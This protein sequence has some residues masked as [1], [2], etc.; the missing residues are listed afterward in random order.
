[1]SKEVTKKEESAIVTTEMPSYL[2]EQMDNTT[3]N[4]EVESGDLVIPRVGIIQALS[5]QRKKNDAA[6]IDGAEEGMIF[7]NVSSELYGE[8]VQVVPVYFKKEYLLWVDRKAG[9]GFRGAFATEAEAISARNE[10]EKANDIEVA[11]T[12]QNFVIIIRS[13]GTIDEAVISMSRSQMKVS[14][15]W[16]SIIR[17]A[18]GPRFSRVYSLSSIEEQNANGDSYL[19]WD[20]KQV[21]FPPEDVFKRAEKL[22]DAVS[23]GVATAD[24]NDDSTTNTESEEY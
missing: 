12:A 2:M 8:E 24:R 17:M 9:G 11:D 7:N 20:I 23:S 3:G 4:E 6:Y 13:D 16:N 5:P 19:N 14:R 1:M 22:Y 10:D 21:G 18:G 15:K